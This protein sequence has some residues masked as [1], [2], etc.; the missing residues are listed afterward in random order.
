[1]FNKTVLL[2][3]NGRL[4]FFGMPQEMLQHFATVE[5]EQHFDTELGGCPSCG[6]TRPEF[7]FDVLEYSTPGPERRYHLRRK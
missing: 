4:V 5:H 7:I 6:T 1:M 3:K 2:D